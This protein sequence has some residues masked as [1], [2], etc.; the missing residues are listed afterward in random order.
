MNDCRGFYTSRCFGTYPAEGIEMLMEGIA[1]AIIENVGRQC[2]MPM[3]PLEV[4]DC[5]GLDT[6]LKIGKTN[7]RSSRSSDYKQGSARGELLS[8]IVEDKGRVGRKARQGLLRVRRRR[9]ADA[10][11]AGAR[12][13]ASKS[14]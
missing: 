10:H 9:Q 13:S 7:G 3:G 5:V 11:L 1:P 14:K 8:W 4:S 12:P 6:A 2:G